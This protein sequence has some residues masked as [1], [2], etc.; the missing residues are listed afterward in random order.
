[1]FAAGLT[2]SLRH[3]CSNKQVCTQLLFTLAPLSHLAVSLQYSPSS[4]QSREVTRLSCSSM[5]EP[6][7][8][9]SNHRL[10]SSTTNLKKEKKP[11]LLINQFHFPYMADV[12]LFIRSN[13]NLSMNHIKLNRFHT[14]KKSQEIKILWTFTYNSIKK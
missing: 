11:I 8:H 1:M 5:T 6:C 10:T 13:L 14:R 12:S 9:V 2:Q 4:S 7:P 3:A